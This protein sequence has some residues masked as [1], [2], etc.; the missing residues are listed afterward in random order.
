MAMGS[1]SDGTFRFADNEADG[2]LSFLE[3][4]GYVH[5]GIASDEYTYNGLSFFGTGNNNLQNKGVGSDCDW[6]PLYWHNICG[7]ARNML[8][9]FYGLAEEGALSGK[10]LRFLFQG[11]APEKWMME[12]EEYTM[13]RFAGLYGMEYAGMAPIAP[14][15][16]D[17]RRNYENIFIN[18][19]GGI[20]HGGKTN[21]RKDCTWGICP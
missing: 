16:A 7:S 3:R 2:N 4:E 11:A 12:A 5:D 19:I 10:S 15:Q 17:C 20:Q 13:K 6:P 9:R 18:V 1:V 14:R 21:S 8:D